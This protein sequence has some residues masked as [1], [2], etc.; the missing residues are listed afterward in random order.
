MNNVIYSNISVT[1]APSIIF[2]KY[3]CTLTK[4]GFWMQHFYLQW[5]IFTLLCWYFSKCCECCLS[6]AGTQPSIWMMNQPIRLSRACCSRTELLLQ[7][8]ASHPAGGD[9]T[10]LTDVG[11]QNFFFFGCFFYFLME[12]EL[13][14]RPT[15]IMQNATAIMNVFFCAKKMLLRCNVFDKRPCYN[16]S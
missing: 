7:L 14:L 9:A 16:G 2:I 5:S 6:P 4:T 1:V 15:F 8:L 13:Q 3:Y 11:A 10:L 12:K